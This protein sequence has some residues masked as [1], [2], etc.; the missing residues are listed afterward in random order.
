MTDT[1]DFMTKDQFVDHIVAGVIDAATNRI[2]GD[3]Y[4]GRDNLYA[5]IEN[6]VAGII[7]DKFIKDH[8]IEILSKIDLDEIIKVTKME[9]VKGLAGQR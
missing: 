2:L 8:K 7:A 4:G 5:L 6:K 9:I 1:T 3:R